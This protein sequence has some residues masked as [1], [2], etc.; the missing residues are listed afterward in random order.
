MKFQ[1]NI[2]NRTSIRCLKD[3]DALSVYWAVYPSFQIS[4]KTGMSNSYGAVGQ[5]CAL[6]FYAG[7]TIF[8]IITGSIFSFIVYSSVSQLFSAYGTF[9]NFFEILGTLRRD[10]LIFV[11]S[12]LYKKEVFTLNLS[13]IFRFQ[14]AG[15]KI[16]YGGP[17]WARGPPV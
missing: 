5:I 13:R 2:L 14:D 1:I 7:Q 15:H 17:D 6:G 12:V 3:K 10:F 11:S 16:E 4:A 8:Q 9:W